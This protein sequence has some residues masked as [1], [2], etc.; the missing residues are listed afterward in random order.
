M[1]LNK[2]FKVLVVFIIL[3]ISYMF[4]DFIIYPEL[5]RHKDEIK[6]RDVSYTS[7]SKHYIEDCKKES[8]KKRKFPPEEIT[9][10]K[11]NY[12]YPWKFDKKF[13]KK[14]TESILKILNDSSSYE[15]GEIGTPFFNCHLTFHSNNGQ[16]V[17]LTELSAEGQTYS[18]PSL[19]RMKWGFIKN[20]KYD[21]LYEILRK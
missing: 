12:I 1:M 13:D 7:D 17:G 2:I 19:Y 8:L 11:L 5:E 20:Q 15:W 14:E 21:E 3:A 6:Y 4:F 18:Y 10:S 16:I 9:Y